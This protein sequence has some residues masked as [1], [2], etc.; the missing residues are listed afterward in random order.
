MKMFWK[1]LRN[2]R[3]VLNIINLIKAAFED[4]QLTESEA[5][6]VLKATGDILVEMKIIEK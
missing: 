6:A 4:H 3:K 2:W 1:I 5:M